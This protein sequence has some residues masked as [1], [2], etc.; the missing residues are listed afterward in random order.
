MVS[1]CILWWLNCVI[2][3]GQIWKFSKDTD[4]LYHLTGDF[5]SWS[6]PA[7]RSQLPILSALLQSTTTQLCNSS[8]ITCT[9]VVWRNLCS[10]TYSYIYIYIYRHQVSITFLN[11][12]DMYTDY[13]QPSL[14]RV[15]LCSNLQLAA[16]KSAAK[17][18]A[19]DCNWPCRAQFMHV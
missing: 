5:I 14:W 8:D 10:C 19:Y 9:F 13:C 2:H 7:Q 12:N 3:G 16:Q 17:L 11:H 6:Y 4:L 18:Y 1:S 15:N